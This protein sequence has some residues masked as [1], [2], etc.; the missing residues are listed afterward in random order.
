MKI[1]IEKEQKTKEIE[2]YGT[3]RELLAELDINLETVLI[4]RNNE[5]ITENENVE[6]SDDIKI[7]SVVS[8]G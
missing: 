4:T 7:I 8:G 3:V 5:I 1:F 2:F 6:N